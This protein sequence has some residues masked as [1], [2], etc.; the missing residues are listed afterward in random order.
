MTSSYVLM[1]SRSSVRRMPSTVVECRLCTVKKLLRVCVIPRVRFSR[2]GDS[3]ALSGLRRESG[4]ARARVHT[5]VRETLHAH[6]SL[7]RVSPTPTVGPF[8]APHSPCRAASRHHPPL[9]P[10]LEKVWPATGPGAPTAVYI[11][12]PDLSPQKVNSVMECRK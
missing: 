9:P 10:P 2:L 11:S 7:S 4:R 3:T 1:H 6:A 12:L 5:G 8:A